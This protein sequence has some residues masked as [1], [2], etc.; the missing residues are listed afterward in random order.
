MLYLIIRYTFENNYIS[1][2]IYLYIYFEKE[3]KNCINVL[4]GFI[5]FKF[6]IKYI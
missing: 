6:F 5:V 1:I 3:D 4:Y 2:H